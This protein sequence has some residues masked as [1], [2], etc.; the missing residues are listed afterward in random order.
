MDDDQ[1]RLQ[2]DI[3]REYVEFID[4]TVSLIIVIRYF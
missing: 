4:D 1:T 3:Q 2:L